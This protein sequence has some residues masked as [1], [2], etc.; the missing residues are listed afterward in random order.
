[1]SEPPDSDRREQ[2][3]RSRRRLNVIVALA[4]GGVL[5]LLAAGCLAVGVPAFV[6]WLD[7]P[8]TLTRAQLD[9]ARRRWQENGPLDYNLDVRVTGLRAADYHVEVRDGEPVSATIDGRPLRNRRT[10][11][12]WSVPGMLA[13]IESDVDHVEERAEQANP[14]TAR[15]TLRG[16]FDPQYGFP[17]RYHRMEWGEAGSDQEVTWEVTSFQPR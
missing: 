15:L 14:R 11:G 13:T 16:D 5:G 17:R 9:E 3:R 1:M 4:A 7:R 10:F 6:S 12:T 2:A 8:T